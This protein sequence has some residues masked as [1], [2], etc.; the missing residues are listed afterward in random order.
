MA[1]AQFQNEP[2][3]QVKVGVNTWDYADDTSRTQVLSIWHRI[4]EG[5]VQR[6][7]IVVEDPAGTLVVVKNDVVQIKEQTEGG[8]K[9]AFYG[10]VVHPDRD[11]SKIIINC[12]GDEDKKLNDE[13]KQTQLYEQYTQPA[14]IPPAW[15]NF[16]TLIGDRGISK[17]RLTGSPTSEVDKAAVPLVYLATISAPSPGRGDWDK[18]A[19][20]WTEIVNSTANR[21]HLFQFRAEGAFLD[22]VQFILMNTSVNDIIMDVSIQRDTG[23]GKAGA[24]VGIIA[25][26]TLLK[27]LGI[28]IITVGSDTTGLR[29]PLNKAQLY[30]CVL[31]RQSTLDTDTFRV[32][33]ATG[34]N[35]PPSTSEFP[36]RQGIGTGTPYGGYGY[37]DRFTITG[38]DRLGFFQPHFRDW[39]SLDYLRDYVD[40]GTPA[41]DQHDM[42]IENESGYQ[43]AQV[44]GA[45]GFETAIAAFAHDDGSIEAF[46]RELLELKYDPS[47]VVSEVFTPASI[48]YWEVNQETLWETT[49]KLASLLI[50]SAG[51]H[52]GRVFFEFN[53]ATP[54]DPLRMHIQRRKLGTDAEYATVGGEDD[55]VGEAG[56]LFRM[57][58]A[59]V[60]EEAATRDNM[61]TVIG[62]TAHGD[63]L[64]ATRRGTYANQPRD[65]QKIVGDGKL[66]RP[67]EVAARA[68]AL[69]QLAVLDDLT[70]WFVVPGWAPEMSGHFAQNSYNNI[71]KL[72][73]SRRNLSAGRKFIVYATECT[74]DGG[75][76]R[77]KC[78]FG[79]PELDIVKA[80]ADGHRLLANEIVKDGFGGIDTF[81]V[82][83]EKALTA[84]PAFCW[85][86]NASGGAPDAWD[87]TVRSPG[88]GATSNV[89][90]AMTK[91]GAEPVWQAIFNPW[92]TFSLKVGQIE[93]FDASLVSLGASVLSPNFE[94]SPHQRIV[95]EVK[96]L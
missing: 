88:P 29:V 21:R 68:E 18:E 7:K 79:L 19:K 70:G 94:Y 54:L 47:D 81:Y 3:Y 41:A 15:G 77:T 72:K 96:K 48:R 25:S 67:E 39:V 5:E 60:R 89:M 40:G 42:N 56:L 24:D 87:D 30:W 90:P 26:F 28:Q 22:Q 4:A 66:K 8:F 80:V 20:V 85:I 23:G 10:Y 49:Q 37:Y 32:F 93:F 91:Y 16:H 92:L 76:A 46:L 44:D 12:L 2:K 71:I 31:H 27:G 13:L 38:A 33:G 6:A 50:D 53:D 86:R 43:P 65:R 14:R 69:A 63:P 74:L 59:D 51:T 55:L 57:S 73:T 34:A 35:V 9:T 83:V 1:N 61:Y 62:R 84:D 45:A 11:G 78:W 82:Y 58:D 36:Y 64:Y 17:V 52:R 75:G 95:V